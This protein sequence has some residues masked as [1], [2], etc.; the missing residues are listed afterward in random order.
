[1]D[2]RLDRASI[3]RR[4]VA[5]GLAA[6]LSLGTARGAEAT[7]RPKV[8]TTIAMLADAVRALAGER[9]EVSGLMGE[10]VDPHTYRQTR[11]DIVRLR[12]AD[13]VLLNGLH[14]DCLLYTSRCV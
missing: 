6:L 5:L 10:G 1:M 14:L 3:G 11:S 2:V 4:E 7:G 12:H 9:V 13:L 8:V